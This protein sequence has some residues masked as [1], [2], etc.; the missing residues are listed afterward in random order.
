LEFLQSDSTDFGEPQAFVGV[1]V[2]PLPNLNPEGTA[3]AEPD[4]LED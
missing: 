1:P 2:K 3:V 4:Q